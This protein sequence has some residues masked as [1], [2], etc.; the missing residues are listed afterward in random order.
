MNRRHAAKIPRTCLFAALLL[1]AC[2]SPPTGNG[3]VGHV[4]PRITGKSLSGDY[5][6]LADY[7]GQV[8][9][10]NLWATWCGPCRAE[11]PALEQLHQTYKKRGFTVFGVSVDSERGESDVR[12]MV[13]NIKLSYPVILD[14]SGRSTAIYRAPGYPTSVLVGRDG[15]VRWR[16]AGA[17]T[18]NDAELIAAIEAA[19]AQP[20]P[21]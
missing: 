7:A 1:L 20:S 14:P 10:I 3:A 19:L 18:A 4:A 8:V 15:Q 11:L 9:L 12:A 17:L 6:Q 13:R 21:E 5:V 2:P 16:R